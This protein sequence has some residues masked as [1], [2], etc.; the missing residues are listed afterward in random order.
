M[1]KCRLIVKQY[2]FRRGIILDFKAN[3]KE[4][5]VIR[6]WQFLITNNQVFNLI[7]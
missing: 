1:R 5:L 7:D 2:N 3:K 4:G 6:D